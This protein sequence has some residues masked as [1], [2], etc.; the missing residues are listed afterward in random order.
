M[1]GPFFARGIIH[2]EV[3]E[4]LQLATCPRKKDKFQLKLSEVLQDTWI[5]TKFG[6]FFKLFGRIKRICSFCE[7]FFEVGNK[8]I[9]YEINSSDNIFQLSSWT[10]RQVQPRF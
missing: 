2:P 8:F 7:F 1:R 6:S 4:S 9:G 10:A 5:D 3:F